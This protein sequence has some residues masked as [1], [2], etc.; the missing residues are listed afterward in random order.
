MHRFAPEMRPL[1]DE[2]RVR[3]ESALDEAQLHGVLSHVSSFGPSQGRG[4]TSSEGRTLRRIFEQFLVVTASDGVLL[5]GASCL[6]K[7]LPA[8]PAGLMDAV[9]RVAS[10]AQYIIHCIGFH[11]RFLVKSLVLF[12]VIFP[13]LCRYSFDLIYFFSPFRL[14]NWIT[15]ILDTNSTRS[16]TTESLSFFWHTWD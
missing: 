9:L 5:L 4:R 1:G 10:S 7:T 12:V 3:T 8:G 2:R 13:R 16:K 14:W 11:I 15:L 6:K